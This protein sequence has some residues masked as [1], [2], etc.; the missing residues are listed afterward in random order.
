LK[1]L[2]RELASKPRGSPEYSR[3]AKSI[4]SSRRP[5]LPK[6]TRGRVRTPKVSQLRDENRRCLF[7]GF[8]TKCFGV[9]CVFASLSSRRSL[10]Q[11]SAENPLI[12]LK[13]RGALLPSSYRPLSEQ[14]NHVT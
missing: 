8:R 14:R 3:R 2:S 13:C 5:A 4:K 11:N 9:R 12:Q 10:R 1:A 7:C 6:A